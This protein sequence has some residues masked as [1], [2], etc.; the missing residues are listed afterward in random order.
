MQH[1]VTIIQD[2]GIKLRWPTNQKS[3]KRSLWSEIIFPGTASQKL[4]Q[5]QPLRQSHQGP[6]PTIPMRLT[7]FFAQILQ[8]IVR[9]FQT[10]IRQVS[11]RGF[12][13][14]LSTTSAQNWKHGTSLKTCEIDIFVPN[15]TEPTNLFTPWSGSKCC[16]IFLCSGKR[17]LKTQACWEKATHGYST[18]LKPIRLFFVKRFNGAR[19]C[20]TLVAH[21]FGAILNPERCKTIEKHGCPCIPLFLS[22]NH[23]HFYSI[24][25]LIKQAYFIIFLYPLFINQKMGLSQNTV[26]QIS[27]LIIIFPIKTIILEPNL[28]LVDNTNNI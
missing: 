19:C 1:Y 9:S 5:S 6:S 15:L 26:P 2:H 23:D 21:F 22:T 25:P 4:G 8:R 11:P 18:P 14:R 16:S 20:N 12:F 27:R 13:L 10:R 17:Q 3:K 28:N 24:I 7:K